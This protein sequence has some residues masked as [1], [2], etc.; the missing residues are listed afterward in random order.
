MRKLPST[1]KWQQYALVTGRDLPGLFDNMR[2]DRATFFEEV[3]ASIA[4][5]AFYRP[6]A[7]FRIIIT[8]FTETKNQLWTMDK[9]QGCRIQLQ[10]LGDAEMYHVERGLTDDLASSEE[11]GEESFSVAETNQS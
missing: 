9:W 10:P 11:S 5:Q 1:L 4:Y 7:Q 8:R 6:T 2:Y 3:D